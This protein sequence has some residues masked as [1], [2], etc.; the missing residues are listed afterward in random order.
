MVKHA[1]FVAGII[2]AANPLFAQSLCM[3]SEKNVFSFQEKKSKKVMS[4]CAG[5]N[6]G[7]LVYRFGKP[8]KVDLQFPA[9]LD[10]SSWGKFEF[11]GLRRAGGRSNAGFGEY[12]LSFVNGN[13]EY[14]VF[15]EWSDEDSSYSIGI[16]VQM[17]GKSINLAGDRKTQQGSLILLESESQRIRNIANP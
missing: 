3:D 7:H 10:A 4:V 16:N 11:S 9:H 12:S 5:P 2:S 14:I 13:A 8:E 15:Q 6:S 1:V 17:N